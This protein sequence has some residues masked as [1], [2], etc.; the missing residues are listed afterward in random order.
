MDKLSITDISASK[1]LGK[2]VEIPSS[3]NPAVLVAIPRKD[4]RDKYS[5]SSSELPFSGYDV[6]HC[7]EFSSMTDRN[8]PFTRVLKIKYSSNSE[9]IVESKSLKLYLNSFNMSHFGDSVLISLK[10]CKEIIEKDLS[11]LL[12]TKVEVNFLDGNVYRNVFNNYVDLSTLID[13]NDLNICDFS[14]NPSLLKISKSDNVSEYF[15]KFEA[16]RSNCRVTYQPDFGDVYIYYKSDKFIEYGSLVKYLVSFRNEYHFHEECCEMIYK[17]I[18]DL[19]GEDA[20]IMVCALYTRRG[21]IDISP[22]RYSHGLLNDDIESM[23][24]MN[25]FA[26]S[27]IKQ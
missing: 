4:N 11:D 17:R 5:I 26:R 10:N 12:K 25:I 21:G 18:F 24:D 14:E 22:I 6:W 8:L 2:R 15:L 27:G 9:Y 19:L 16:L 7:Y 1:L 23:C 13:E 3:Y 20:Y